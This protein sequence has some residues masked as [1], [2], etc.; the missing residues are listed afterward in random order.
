ML[1]NT[2]F[3]SE[4]TLV[5][6]NQAWYVSLETTEIKDVPDLD[7]GD[8]DPNF[9]W[10]SQWAWQLNI[11]GGQ[12]ARHETMHPRRRALLSI[13]QKGAFIP[14]RRHADFDFVSMKHG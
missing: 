1:E 14:A 5:V 7:A 11:L 13:K 12:V 4:A 10:N 3:T 2:T 9:V 6:S 8:P